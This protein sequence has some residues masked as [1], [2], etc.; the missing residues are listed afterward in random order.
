MSGV[1]KQNIGQ[2]YQLTAVTPGCRQ[3]VGFHAGSDQAALIEASFLRAY[4]ALCA[5]DPQCR[6]AWLNGRLKL[7]CGDRVISTEIDLEELNTKGEHSFW[8]TKE[9]DS[10]L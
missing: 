2:I 6:D 10:Q 5:F 9:L 8:S 1:A 7:V 4:H 3:H